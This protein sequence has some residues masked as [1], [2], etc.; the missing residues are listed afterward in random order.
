MNWDH[1]HST[2]KHHQPES[3]EEITACPLPK[4]DCERSKNATHA[5]IISE[6]IRHDIHGELGRHAKIIDRNH[7]DDVV[8]GNVWPVD[9]DI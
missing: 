8:S 9:D 5:A 2:G 4:A 6:M 1:M 7:F 3:F